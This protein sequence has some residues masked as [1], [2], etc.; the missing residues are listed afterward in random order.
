MFTYAQLEQLWMDAGGSTLSAPIAAAIALAESGGCQYA[1][2]A[3]TDIRPVRQ[4]VYRQTGGEFSIG[5]WQINT[6][7]DAH[8]D[9]DRDQLFNPGYNAHAAVAIASG[10]NNFRPWSTF[11]SG[12]YRSHLGGAAAPTGRAR[13]PAP[14]TQLPPGATGPQGLA[15]SPSNPFKAWHQLT[16]ALG[17]TIPTQSRRA[18]R[19]KNRFPRAV[20]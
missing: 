3:P 5:L 16:M 8:P 2:A 13:N 14:R 11:T 15:P 18:R 12:A 1:L 7:P 17:S 19:A 4:C 10:G 6:A 20:R 9:Y